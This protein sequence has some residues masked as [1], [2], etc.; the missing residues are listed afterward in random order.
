MG[1]ILER[2]RDEERIAALLLASSNPSASKSI[3][4]VGQTGA[5]LSRNQ[6]AS[7]SQAKPRQ[8]RAAASGKTSRTGGSTVNIPIPYSTEAA[9]QALSEEQVAEKESGLDPATLNSLLSKQIHVLEP[10]PETPLNE[11]LIKEESHPGTSIDLP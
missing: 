4:D 10:I 2:K 8:S 1:L 11:S 3:E 7:K 9:H 6:S 5:A